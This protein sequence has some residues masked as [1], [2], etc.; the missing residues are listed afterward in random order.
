MI[1]VAVQP[2]DRDAA[3]EFFELCKTPWEFYRP[4]HQYEV[5]V[6]TSETMPSN[7]PGLVL[8]YSGSSRGFKLRE[9]TNVRS[10]PREPVISHAG[11]NIPIYGSVALFPGSPTRQALER[12]TQEPVIH[13][14]KSSCG[15]IVRVGYDLFH[16]IR[17][18]L[19]T[20]QPA[21]N[22]ASAAVELHAWLFKDLITRAGV[23]FLEVPPVPAGF[24]FAACLT[25]DVD[26]PLLRNHRFDLTAI[27]FL[28]RASL[29]S[30]VNF[31][32][33][34][35]SFVRMW[36]NWLAAAQLPFVQLGL[37]P[38]IWRGFDRYL[39]IEA[40][41]PSTFFVIPEKDN[42][43]RTRD[44]SGP[45]M[46][47]CRYELKEIAPIL[48]GIASNGCGVA[49]HGLNAWLA[50]NDAKREKALFS[51]Q[52]API[53]MENGVRM[54]WLCFDENS[55]AALEAAGFAYDSSI[56]YN[57]TV[58]FRAG[59]TQVYR[60]IGTKALLE[61]P[62]HIMDTALF[63]PSF[64]NLSEPEAY[65]LAVRLMED[66]TR[67]GGVLTLNWHDRSIAAERQWGQFYKS[68]LK[69]LQ[70]RGAW[71]A[72]AT[73]AIAWF[74]MRRSA[75]VDSSTLQCGQVRILGQITSPERNLPPLTIRIHKPHVLTDSNQLSL[76][77]NP[78]FVDLN[79]KD[80]ID[81]I[82]KL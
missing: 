54:H 65:R 23:P 10:G 42:P 6:A 3:C 16:E 64:L 47:A 55:P 30:L 1:G 29:G 25:H 59:T 50:T 43:G 80:R 9:G 2:I 21:C 69:E 24:A 82:I 76:A 26:H 28:Y 79:L 57:E 51:Q 71:F 73:Q 22:A 70:D 39:T 62:L 13:V 32:R 61:L 19:N 81:T 63:F 78:G 31:F 12:L 14:S 58:G 34:R 67:F 49:L 27:G 17:H 36:S 15:L 75:V 46:R 41:R 60:P 66:F 72:T 56:G 11:N 18:L 35:L 45:R 74:Q 7:A 40:G 33:S 48:A 53:P 68:L 20:G 8:I 77:T 52:L 44:G 38:D 5:V 4:G 37:F